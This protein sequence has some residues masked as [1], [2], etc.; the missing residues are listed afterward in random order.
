M[1]TTEQYSICD[2]GE[3]VISNMECLIVLFTFMNNLGSQ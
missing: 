3:L 2:I 1:L